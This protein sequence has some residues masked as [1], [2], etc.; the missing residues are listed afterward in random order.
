MKVKISI[1]VKGMSYKSVQN[2]HNKFENK[3]KA[4]LNKTQ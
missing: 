2:T 3:S 4:E 1:L